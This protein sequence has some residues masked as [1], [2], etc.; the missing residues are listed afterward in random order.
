VNE[1]PRV[2][3][4]LSLD[5]VLSHAKRLARLVELVEAD[6]LPRARAKAAL[7]SVLEG[8]DPATL[9]EAPVDDLAPIIASVLAANP[10][11]V[12]EYRGG[13]A[14]LLG[15]FVGQVMKASG[16]KASPAAVNQLVTAALAAS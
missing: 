11:K 8:T 6:T 16:G 13:R 5:S 9:V 4:D 1:V 10:A 3:E 15:F 14:G 2:A 12:A 7:L